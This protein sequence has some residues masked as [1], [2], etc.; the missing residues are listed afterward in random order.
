LDLD[1]RSEGLVVGN[2][3]RV[4]FIVR[5]QGYGPAYRLV[6]R[7]TGGQ[8][9]GQVIT[10][11]RIATLN[12]GDERE[13][14]L[15]LRPLASGDTVPLRVSV[16]YANRD[17]QDC[18]YQETLYMKVT[19]TGVDKTPSQV[20]LRVSDILRVV[21]AG[22]IASILTPSGLARYQDI[23]ILIDGSRSAGYGVRVLRSPAGEAS[24][25][26]DLPFT[27][28][29]L[30]E[31]L[32]Q[33]EAGPRNESLLR[34]LGSGLFAALL[35]GNVGNRFRSSQGKVGRDEGLRLRLR[36]EATELL[37]VPWE[38][39]YDPEQRQFLCLTRQTPIVRYLP[40]PRPA[41]CQ[42]VPPPLQMLVVPASPRDMPPLEVAQ[43][44][45][46]LRQAVQPL[47]DEGLLAVKVLSPPTPRALRAHLVDSACHILHFIGHG[48]FDAQG[49]YI[50]LENREGLARDLHAAELKV[51]FAG[52]SLRLAVLA[53]CLTA[54]DTAAE[55][56]SQR[57][58]LGV[59]PALVD[60]GV[61]SVVA[62]QFSLTDVGGRAFAQDFYEMLARHKPVEE[63]V[64]QA[65]VAVML[66]MGLGCR[67]WAAPVLYMRGSP[68]VLFPE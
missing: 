57:A 9:E 34:E 25:Q 52:T 5:N 22:S 35:T 36:V 66:E 50:S 46:L 16:E 64:D 54:R 13:E 4:Q 8:F 12:A 40:I 1:V 23:D 67:D 2:W 45:A 60:A 41:A 39:L 49:G 63:A 48:S 28:Q 24:G 55:G 61:P 10:T 32:G 21:G 51:L 18:D 44:V 7:A 33:I 30:S 42:P 27:P 47:M 3:S 58:Y 17:G 56:A 65:R 19:R 14:W 6:V 29:A 68:G 31:T 53:A 43:E 15:D 11:Q 38:L 62:M 37:S 59:A 20:N 26:L